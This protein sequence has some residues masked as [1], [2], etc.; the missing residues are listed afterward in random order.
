MPGSSSQVQ[1][2]PRPSQGPRANRI[3]LAELVPDD[4][5]GIESIG[6][7]NTE[8]SA[9]AEEELLEEQCTFAASRDP[10]CHIV[11]RGF[12]TLPLS[13]QRYEP[14]KNL[15]IHF[16]TIGWKVCGA[17]YQHDFTDLTLTGPKCVEMRA[18]VVNKFISTLK[19]LVWVDCFVMSMV[20]ER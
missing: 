5:D 4:D 7:A 17:A 14:P 1:A 3:E 15:T 2:H 16:Y 13:A 6:D 8:D 12:P 18:K 20:W 19:P 10:A 9:D 11:S